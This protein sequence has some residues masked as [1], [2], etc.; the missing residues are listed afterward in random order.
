MLSLSEGLGERNVPWCGDVG[1]LVWSG[2]RLRL[3]GVV[4]FSFEASD[5][6]DGLAVIGGGL[7]IR[8]WSLRLMP[9]VYG[10]G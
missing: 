2:G 6:I 5:V 3:G 4:I 10:R 9:I 8:C 7:T 1:Q